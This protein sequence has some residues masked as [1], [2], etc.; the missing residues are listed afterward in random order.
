M[1]LK[2]K[3]LLLAT[4]PL[5]LAISLISTLV[6]Y[7]A[8]SLA[9]EE[10]AAFE[11][12]M[13]NAKKLELLNYLSLAQTSIGHI[14]EPA[15]AE[16]PKAKE[17][18]KEILKTLTYGTDG[19]F[20][21]YDFE[22]TNLVH[23]KQPELIGK[24]WWGLK[25]TTGNL[26]IQHLISR[27]REGGG[28]HRYLWSKPSSG[29]IADKISYAVSLDKWNWMLGTG[30]YIDDVISQVE[31]FEEEVQDRIWQTSII[32]LIITFTSLGVVFVTGIVINLHERRLADVKLK[33]LTQRIIETQEEERGRVA[34]ELHDGISQILVSI[35]YAHEMA[36]NKAQKTES[37]TEEIAAAIGKGANAL[38]IAINEVRR[39]SR[40]LRPSIL[41]DLG[42]S[43]AL[44]S[45]AHEFSERTDIK[46][47]ISTVAFKDLL[48]KDAKT[49]LYRVAQETLT[50]IERHSGADHVKLEL[51][52]PRGI[53]T[54]SI[55]DNGTGFDIHGLSVKKDPLAG[56]GLRNMQERLEHHG[57]ELQVTSSTKGTS[58]VAILPKGILRTG[59]EN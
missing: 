36:L 40:D 57:G 9:K 15:S 30:L 22:G 16:N 46:V 18:V 49:T 58:I 5:I 48:P 25:D 2:Q 37:D 27:A 12:N 24:N 20:F 42:L 23:P 59:G 38:N 44:E 45:L 7:Q 56:I 52:A 14:Y 53:V 3:V 32:I 34:R 55:H 54:L 4:V 29:E 28:F 11:R 33:E 13:L 51:S 1:N 47:Q 6:T 43:P 17:Q 35:K 26:V 21:V 50:N 10:I 19:Y 39:I 31:A 41:D 8:Q